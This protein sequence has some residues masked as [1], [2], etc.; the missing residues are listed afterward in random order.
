[1]SLDLLAEAATN[2]E[3]L[4]LARAETLLLGQCMSSCEGSRNDTTTLTADIAAFQSSA[5]RSNT[6]TGT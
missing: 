3:P 6:Q 4:I 2:V 5:H 1:M